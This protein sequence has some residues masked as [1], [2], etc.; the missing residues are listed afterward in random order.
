MIDVDTI[1]SIPWVVVQSDWIDLVK[2]DLE[3]IIKVYALH[4]CSSG[5]SPAV[6]QVHSIAQ[7]NHM[8]R[9]CCK[10]MKTQQALMV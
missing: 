1:T 5:L 10:K 2:T 8:I 3:G 4:R 7:G 6:V 9:I